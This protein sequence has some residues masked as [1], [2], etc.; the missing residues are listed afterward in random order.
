MFDRSGEMC[1]ES[2]AVLGGLIAGAQIDEDGFVYVVMDKTLRREGK[3][4]LSGCAG[5]FGSTK[6]RLLLLAYL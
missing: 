3:D 1:K 6:K 4:F 2:P 5:H